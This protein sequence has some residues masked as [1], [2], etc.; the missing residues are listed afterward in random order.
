MCVCVCVCTRAATSVR[1]N[2][3]GCHHKSVHLASWLEGRPYMRAI[4]WEEAY[5]MFQTYVKVQSEQQMQAHN[6]QPEC[7]IKHGK[8]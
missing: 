3:S 4:R 8:W 1:V 5:N 2:M 7:I 6:A